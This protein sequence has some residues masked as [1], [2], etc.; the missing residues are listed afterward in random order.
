ME[1]F[2]NDDV[3][4]MLQMLKEQAENNNES[5]INDSIGFYISPLSISQRYVIKPSLDPNKKASHLFI[6]NIL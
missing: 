5:N 1:N 3:K 2:N 4:K 6:E